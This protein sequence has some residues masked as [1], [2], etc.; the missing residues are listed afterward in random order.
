[1]ISDRETNKIFF[2][3]RLKVD[4]S[5]T[6]IEI[7]TIL[8]SFDIKP[9]FLPKT[10]DIWARDFM[11]IQINNKKFIE[12]R[13]DPDY[14]QGSWKDKKTREIKTYPD[15]VCE[16]INLK[17]SKTDIILDG[18]NVVKSSNSII[19]TDKVI[20]ENSLTYGKTKLLDKLHTLFEVDKVILIPWDIVCEFGHSDGMLRFINDETVLISGFYKSADIDLK[21]RLLRSLK[22]AHLNWEWLRCSNHEVERNIAYINF[23][24]TNDLILVPKLNSDE[25]Y[26]AFEQ[27]SMFYPEYYEKDRIAQVDMT[28]IVKLGGAL[29]CIS[30]TIME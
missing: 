3:D 16:Q 27:I 2:A 24:Q 25:D 7:E 29:N 19:L 21:E 5:Q 14:L 28:K 30:W 13:Y 18:G 22:K 12:Y 10:K 11:P 23:L 1:M 26:I 15:I 4:F 17:T 6:C 20:F 8:N 9:N